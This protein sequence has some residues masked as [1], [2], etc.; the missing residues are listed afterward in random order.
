[1]HFSP[2]TPWVKKDIKTFNDYFT[3]LGYLLGESEEVV[4][5]AVFCPIRSIYF[6]YKH[7]D[8]SVVDAIEKSYAETVTMLSRW[9]IPYHIIDETILEKHGSCEGELLR[10]GNCVYDT[11]I[12]PK[13]ETMSKANAMLM[14][15][16]YE[17]GGNIYLW[18]EHLNM[19]KV[20]VI[21]TI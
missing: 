18:M 19:W 16:F 20:K 12:F 2:V 10:V 8:A 9:N 5:V 3:K 15:K 21:S 7:H 11:V 6:E 14:E 17:D 1:M 13:T 4:S